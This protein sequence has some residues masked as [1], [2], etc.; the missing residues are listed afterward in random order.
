MT[1]ASQ[2]A[3][4]GAKVNSEMMYEDLGLVDGSSG[5]LDE[6][7]TRRREGGRQ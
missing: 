2:G 1:A 7:R 4:V 6:E 5:Y 3:I